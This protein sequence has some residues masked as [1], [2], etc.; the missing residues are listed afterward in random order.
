MATWKLW[1]RN[2]LIGGIILGI[3]VIG[4]F[5][6]RETFLPPHP[7]QLQVLTTNTRLSV[8]ALSHDGT[9]VAAGDDE[10][11]IWLWEIHN[12]DLQAEMIGHQTQV[13]ALTFVPHSWHLVS[14]SADGQ[15]IF[16]DTTTGKR[17]R[18]LGLI[19]P[20][21]PVFQLDQSGEH[22]IFLFGVE[23]LAPDPDGEWIVVTGE[24]GQVMVIALDTGGLL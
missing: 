13:K 5:V 16:W 11:R 15:V 9:F 19:D 12:G 1:I 2:S 21:E 8:V 7:A 10:G 17:V 14:G 22:Q 23:T 18:D 24:R 20:G 3:L 4:I 6:L